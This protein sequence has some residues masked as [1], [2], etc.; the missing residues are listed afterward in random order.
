MKI[1]IC[2]NKDIQVPVGDDVLNA[3]NWLRSKTPINFEIEYLNVDIKPQFKFFT[4]ATNGE[5]YY[6]TTGTKDK[7]LPLIPKGKYQAVIFMYGIENYQLSDG[8]ITSWTFW[9]GLYPETEY[10]EIITNKLNDQT[11]WIDMSLSHEMMHALC[12]MAKRKGRPVIDSMDATLVNGKYESYYK[13]GDRNATDG[14]YAITLKSLS[15]FWDIFKDPEYKYFT[16]TEVR[17]LKP[18]LVKLLDKARE[19]AGVPF[20][21]T[22]GLRTVVQN[23]MAGGAEKS[24][25]L[26]GEAVDLKALTSE[27]KFKILKALLNAGVTR[28]GLYPKHIHCDISKDNPQNVAWISNED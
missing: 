27:S 25:H 3:F 23:A 19:E 28:I 2:K 13:N 8:K 6:G 15:P 18:E 20:V 4:T 9:E 17:G 10:C 14:N 11:K 1:L 12:N 22:S 26:T 5:R 21:I 16:A 24:A 7:L